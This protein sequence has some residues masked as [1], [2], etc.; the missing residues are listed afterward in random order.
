MRRHFKTLSD[1]SLI[2]FDRG[3]FDD[4]CVYLTP[5]GASRFAPRDAWY[6]GELQALAARHGA[7][8]L[9]E[10]FVRVY[11]R[12]SAQASPAVLAWITGLS[13]AYGEDALL[14]DQLFTILYAGM[15]AEENKVNG[16]LG[17]R[18]K[19]L[20]M[21]QALIEGMPASEA[22]NYSRN[23]DARRLDGECRRRGF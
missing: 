8:R 7:Y 14:V 12:T 19:R 15:V 17:R 22:A 13:A 20:G 4:W 16:P 3:Q 1:G 6:F 2:E 10:D 23:I 5:P 11:D 18:I 21:Y 9:Y